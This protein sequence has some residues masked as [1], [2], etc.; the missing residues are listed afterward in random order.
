MGIEATAEE[1]GI[2][3]LLDPLQGFV[4]RLGGRPIALPDV[5]ADPRRPAGALL[6]AH[7]DALD[8]VLMA[9][10]G[11][12]GQVLG[13]GRPPS[14]AERDDLD[15]LH[16]TLDRLVHEYAASR[17]IAGVVADIRGGQ[18]VGT[19]HM[20]GVR[21]RTPLGLVAPAPLEDELD[22]PTP[23]MVSG[24]A[25]MAEVDPHA[26]W[27]GARW[28]VRTQDD[29][30]LPARLGMLLGDSSGVD[31]DLTQDTH[32]AAL[33]AATQGAITDAAEPGE[34]SGALDW[35]LY[36]WLHAHRDDP[37]SV[38]VEIAKGRVDDAEMIVT[39][40]HTSITL[41]ARLRPGL[42]ALPGQ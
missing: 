27:R 13:G 34:A 7:L 26:A 23:G 29:R 36:D 1:L 4:W 17:T 2:E 22:I 18:I 5:V 21:A 11:S 38:A 32:R 39:A 14:T 8:A 41:R 24:H 10:A 31:R 16:R 28:I 35:L 6:R 42:L 33:K 9:A 37:S 30:R 3:E 12:L 19:A 20:L 40:A 15:V 25:E